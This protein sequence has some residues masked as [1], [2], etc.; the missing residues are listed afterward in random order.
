MTSRT[1]HPDDHTSMTWPTSP[2][3]P[4]TG[5]PTATPLVLPLSSCTVAAKSDG[6]SAVTCAV[7]VGMSPT[8]GSWSSRS[9]ARSE[10]RVAWLIE[11]LALQRADLAS[12][13]G[14]LGLEVTAVHRAGQEAAD[15]SGDGVDAALHRREG[16]VGAALGP[17]MTPWAW[18]R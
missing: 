12:Q 2:A 11:R 9:R 16:V 1:V 6:L 4:T 18:P 17:E 8:Q 13:L 5:M 14:V 15:G 3:P 7:T 10:F